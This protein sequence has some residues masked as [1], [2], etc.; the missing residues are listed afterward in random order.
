MPN[1]QSNFTDISKE[2]SV[3]L[4]IGVL[5]MR[6]FVDLLENLL[7]ELNE[8]SLARFDIRV[9]LFLLFQEQRQHRSRIRSEFSQNNIDSQVE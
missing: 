5:G 2:L 7:E 3:L 6:T 8:D 4:G 1:K 9:H